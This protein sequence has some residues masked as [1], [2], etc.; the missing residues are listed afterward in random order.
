MSYS[1]KIVYFGA[2]GASGYA[3]AAKGY[4]YD[5]IESGHDVYF[6]TLSGAPVKDTT[7]FYKY[8]NAKLKKLPVFKKSEKLDGADV[9]IHFTPDIWNQ[10]IQSHKE[11]IG[12]KKIIGRTV[13]DFDPI[14]DKWVKEINDSIVNVVSVPSQW[15]KDVF[16][17]SGVKKE[18]IVEAHTIPPISYEKYSIVDIF[19]NARVFSPVPINYQRFA[20][21]VKFLNISSLVS[22]K[23]TGFLIE[24]Y[25]DSFT[26]DDETLLIC[27]FTDKFSNIQTIEKNIQEIILKKIK[28]RDK[29]YAYAPIVVISERLSFDKIQSLH[30]DTDIY[31]NVSK[32]EGFNIP[33]YTAKTKN[34]DIVTPL[35]G[36]VTDY[37]TNYPKLFEVNYNTAN[38]SSFDKNTDTSMLMWINM[39]T[40][41][42]DVSYEDLCNSLKTAYYS[43]IKKC[44]YFDPVEFYQPHTLQTEESS[45]FP[46]YFK[47][48]WHNESLINGIWSD[49]ECETII[50]PDVYKFEVVLET[51]KDIDITLTVNNVEQAYTIKRGQYALK[52]ISKDE[53]SIKIDCNDTVDGTLINRNSNN[54]YGVKIVDIYVN[55][56][57]NITSRLI[58]KDTNFSEHVLAN[59]G[60]LI[61]KS[62]VLTK[63]EY[64]D[65]IIKFKELTD[66]NKY[67]KKINLGKQLS[68]YSHRS[69]WNYVLHNMAALNSNSGVYCDGFIENNFSWR[70]TECVLQKTIPYNKSWVG[71][72]HNPPN[73]P[74]WFSDNNAFTNIILQDPYFLDSLR[75]CKGIYTLSEYHAK[76]IRQYIPFVPVESLYHPTEIPDLQFDFDRFVKNPEKK[77]VTI[78]WWLRKLNAL[79]TV[80]PEGYQKVR[81]L[82]NNKCKETI[83]RLEK[84]ESVINN[85]YIT[86]EQRNSVKILDFLPNDEYDKILAENLVYLDLYDSSANNGII[87][88]M[89]RATPI[90]IN[91]LPAVVEYL[92][93][94]YPLYIDSQ[95]DLE[96]KIKDLDLIK[97]AHLYLKTVRY[98]IEIGHFLE[99]MVNSKIYK[100]L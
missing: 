14:P 68:F 30:D 57:K 43:N 33:C 25:L 54:Q 19:E 66:N 63:G 85:Q 70:K 90:F 81:L 18:V 78:G 98:K 23:N 50:G 38:V 36:G 48:G 32:G 56:I 8:F 60:F 64:G 67:P 73:M 41:C 15:C 21:R 82:P 10:V 53:K 2:D 86:D 80:N 35:H 77:L 76:V 5:L 16:I 26:F 20:K 37:L 3:N 99:S 92:G 45:L 79:Y 96:E 65:I 11:W 12:N 40:K 49:K 31:V 59:T 22:R 94:G 51:I 42:V 89:A 27:K 74:P 61:E 88:C 46:I 55:G 7:S 95:F 58:L 75:K 39:N 47:R 72:I 69:G 52:I 87:E 62:N 1:K 9:V 13:W 97:R 83:F 28:N 4:I 84:I 93:E 34:K 91:R 6:A 71:F 17:N 44:V 24:A 29:D 100:S